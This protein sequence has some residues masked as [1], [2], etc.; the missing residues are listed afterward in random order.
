M[1]RELLAAIDS[2]PS[3]TDWIGA[4]ATALTFVA[5]VVAL[6]FARQ[7]VGEAKTARKQ[8]SDLE[9]ARSQPYVVMYTEPSAAAQVLIDLVIKN[10]GQTAATNIHI[11]LSPWPRRTRGGGQDQEEDVAVPLVIPVLAPGQEWRTLWD[12]GLA[13]RETGL[14]DRH[15]GVVTY[16]GVRRADGSSTGLSTPIVLDWAIYKTR[17]WVEVRSV[18]DAA[19]ALREIQRTVSKWSEG[20]QGPLSVVTRDGDA[21]DARDTADFDERMAE[22]DA[23]DADHADLLDMESSAK[24]TM[25][26]RDSSRAPDDNENL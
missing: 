23:R 4:T 12:N 22:I 5:A 26:V 16:E 17:R 21:R 11:D 14:A 1:F 9:V 18:H 13:R 2:N 6:L 24:T 3:L 15:E 25:R 20:M 7:Q 19:K 8:T 10:F